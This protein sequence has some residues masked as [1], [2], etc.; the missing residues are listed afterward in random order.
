[1]TSLATDLAG[2]QRLSDRLSAGYLEH[3]G[4]LPLGREDGRC[5]AATWL[6]R[7]DPQALDDLRFLFGSDVELIKG[8]E[9]DLRAAIRLVYAATY[10]T[11]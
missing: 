4:V 8:E 1:M 7:P 10:V 11:A 9:D 3:Y 6:D 5:R 2:V